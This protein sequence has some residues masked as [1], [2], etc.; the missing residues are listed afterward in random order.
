MNGEL[1]FL[2]LAGMLLFQ[3]GSRAC[4]APFSSL[5]FSLSL[6][7]AHTHTHTHTHSL[8]LSPSS[9]LP[10]P[11]LGF[12]VVC[13]DASVSVPSLQETVLNM[14]YLRTPTTPNRRFSIDEPDPEVATHH[15]SHGTAATSSAS[16]SNH[17][18]QSGMP[19]LPK[20][21]GAPSLHPDILREG[22]GGGTRSYGAAVSIRPGPGRPSS[23]LQK[24]DFKTPF[25]SSHGGK[26][27]ASSSSTST[28]RSESAS[29]QSQQPFLL[30]ER[31]DHSSFLLENS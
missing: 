19:L 12:V 21:T 1:I 9:P 27:A 23:S 29:S 16:S 24:E 6:S 22:S 10:L 31:F 28:S 7:L 17:S 5:W 13:V 18:H 25:R 2:T 4:C 20:Y 15:Q 8:S 26:T 3:S 14:S 30:A 11:L